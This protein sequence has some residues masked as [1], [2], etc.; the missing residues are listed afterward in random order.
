MLLMGRV[1]GG[2]IAIGMGDRATY[3]VFKRLRA[4]VFWKFG[5]PVVEAL[6]RERA[7]HPRR[8]VT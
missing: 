6:L 2:P 5:R 4:A 7:G 1:R 8:T 3:R